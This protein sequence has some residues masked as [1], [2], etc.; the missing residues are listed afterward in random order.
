M[1]ERCT[2]MTLALTRSGQLSARVAIRK[3]VG[4]DEENESVEGDKGNE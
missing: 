1:A 2:P 4:D 3:I